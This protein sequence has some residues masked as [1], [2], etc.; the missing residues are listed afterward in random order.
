VDI[1]VED[2]LVESWVAYWIRDLSRHVCIHIIT[3]PYLGG[4][5]KDEKHMSVWKAPFL[6]FYRV[7]ERLDITKKFLPDYVLQQL[8]VVFV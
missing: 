8:S 3:I 1:K 6:E 4:L 2:T 7:C 5:L